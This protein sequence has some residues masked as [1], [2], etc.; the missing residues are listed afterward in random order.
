MQFLA[1]SRLRTDRYSDED[2]APLLEDEAQRARMLYIEGSVR[3]IWY[4]GDKRG[5]CSILEADS[6][7]AARAMIESLPLVKAGM[8][9]LEHLVPLLP[10]RGFGPR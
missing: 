9:E 1:L 4:R 3:Q 8:L 6:E 10:Y 2:F 5:A 7:P